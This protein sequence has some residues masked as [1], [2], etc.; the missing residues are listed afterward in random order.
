MTLIG[1]FHQ[2]WGNLSRTDRQLGCD[3]VSS[4]SWTNNVWKE[5]SPLWRQ[6]LLFSSLS[7]V[8]IYYECV[9]SQLSLS[10]TSIHMY[11][12][13]FYSIHSHL[14][15]LSYM[16][17]PTP[18]YATPTLPHLSTAIFPHM[19]GY[20]NG[21]KFIISKNKHVPNSVLL[22]CRIPEGC[23]MLWMG[24]VCSPHLGLVHTPPTHSKEHTHTL[25]KVS[26]RILRS[27]YHFYSPQLCYC[28]YLPVSQSGLSPF[29][30]V[31]SSENGAQN[32]AAIKCLIPLPNSSVWTHGFSTT[33]F[34]YF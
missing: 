21:G 30:W 3:P 9:L 14:I 28:L 23:T 1:N 32:P 22:P 20:K 27:S 5:E 2:S 16:P 33:Y 34:I 13:C 29:L 10:I 11:S 19:N 26:K 18:L 8:V 31:H 4:R 15:Y 25:S 12:S 6:R 24:P 17:L 7:P